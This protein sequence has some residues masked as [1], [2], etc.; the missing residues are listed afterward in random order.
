MKFNYSSIIFAFLF[1]SSIETS[2]SQKQFDLDLLVNHETTNI[3]S[4]DIDSSYE[5][6]DKI[7]G[8]VGNSRIVMLGEQEHGDGLSFKAKAK[9]IEYLVNEKGF[10]LVAFES[11]FYNFTD[12][13]NSIFPD[14]TYGN[15][16][17]DNIYYDWAYCS[18]VQSLIFDFLP[19]HRN[20]KI[21]GIDPQVMF[22]KSSSKITPRLDSIFQALKL[23]ITQAQDYA[24]NMQ[25][26]DSL[27]RLSDINID[28][29][30]SLLKDLT[31][32]ILPFI[33]KVRNEVGDRIEKNNYL[34]QALNN[35]YADAQLLNEFA[36][37]MRN[38][39]KAGNIRDLQMAENLQWLADIKYPKSKIIVW[40]ANPH[41]NRTNEGVSV[42]SSQSMGYDFSL[43]RI[44]VNRP[45]IIGFTAN[46]G[47]SYRIGERT[48]LEIKSASVNTLEYSLHQKGYKYAF[49]NFPDTMSDFK[50]KMRGGFG[51]EFQ[52]KTWKT[53]YDGMFYIDVMKPCL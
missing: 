49:I 51:Y 3:P 13:D 40:A 35:I 29:Q 36:K 24:S 14:S 47:L 17:K 48:K 21:C 9:I 2:Y 45:Y 7:G 12:N 11:S 4:I 28:K 26:I 44:G 8:A 52:K 53:Y 6:F 18:Y 23:P 27:M 41:V 30:S 22:T 42:W 5:N 25:A 31:N 50:F 38:F 32:R 20:V 43:N 33:E 46:S 10:N 15:Y 19:K 1:F 34:L 39:V 16:L 37:K